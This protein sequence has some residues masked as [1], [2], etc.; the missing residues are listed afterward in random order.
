MLKLKNELTLHPP[1]SKMDSPKKPKLKKKKKKDSQ[2]PEPNNKENF[3]E[4]DATLPIIKTS[5]QNEIPE[6]NKL[7]INPQKDRLKKKPNKS[8]NLLEMD[9]SFP[10]IKNKKENQVNSNLEIFV[11]KLLVEKPKPPVDFYEEI[12]PHTQEKNELLFALEEKKEV[13]EENRPCLTPT[14]SFIFKRNEEEL[15]S[16]NNMMFRTRISKEELKDKEEVNPFFMIENNEINRQDHQEKNKETKNIK[17]HSD[18]DKMFQYFFCKMIESPISFSFPC[19]KCLKEKLGVMN[20]FCSLCKNTRQV[21]VTNKNP[22]VNLLDRILNNKL[23]FALDQIS[24]NDSKPK[25]ST[26]KKAILGN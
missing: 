2:K 13:E 12:P 19:Q 21:N 25:E 23:S 4:K 9:A 26:E 20:Q 5:F 14:R 7:E 22:K 17:L 3:L 10:K 15:N 18:L 6:K 16:E 11:E 8:E 24:E 1:P